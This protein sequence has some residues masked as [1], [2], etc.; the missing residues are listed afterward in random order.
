MEETINDVIKRKKFKTK[1]ESKSFLLH[2]GYSVD[3]I[4]KIHKIKPS[5][6]AM[7]FERLATVIEFLNDGWYP[8]WEDETEYK[9]FNYFQMKGGFSCW[10]THYATGT[11]VPSA[12]CLRSVELAEYMIKHHLDLYK[13]LYI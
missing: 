11:T 8:N 10:A 1:R 9:Y 3:E 13:D 6:R 4:I 2:A 12:L 5:K 7:A